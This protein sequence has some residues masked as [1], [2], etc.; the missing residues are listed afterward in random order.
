MSACCSDVARSVVCVCVCLS[1]RWSHCKNGWTYRDADLEAD[2]RG[3]KEP[4]LRI[5]NGWSRSPKGRG[6]FWGVRPPWK[7]FGVSA[8]VCAAKGIIQSSITARQ[9]TL[10]LPTDWSMSLYLVPRQKSSPAMRPI[11]KILWLLVLLWKSELKFSSFSY[12]L[13]MCRKPATRPIY[14]LQSIRPEVESF[15][16]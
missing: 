14:V 1:L 13:F 7:A 6:N 10:M 8:A 3:P 16:W 5:D 11:V 12:R 15:D 2:S 4:C 9:P